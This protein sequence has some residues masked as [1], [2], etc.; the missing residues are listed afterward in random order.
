[1]YRDPKQWAYI[2][3]LILDKG[4]SRRAV[5][6]KT[7]LDRKTVRKMLAL[8]RPPNKASAVSGAEDKLLEAACSLAGRRPSI[9]QSAY[10][11][12]ALY[13]WNRARDLVLKLDRPRGA[14]LLRDMAEVISGPANR[15]QLNSDARI[16]SAWGRVRVRLGRAA[17]GPEA[18]LFGIGW[19]DCCEERCGSQ[20]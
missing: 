5:A 10:R 12:R 9:E 15:D 13:L 4:A 7:G 20:T 18:S 19:T 16:P 3:R 2:R 6:R 8:P 17:H 11:R 1:M 14:A